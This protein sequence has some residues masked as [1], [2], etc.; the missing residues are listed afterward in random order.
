MWV[1]MAVAIGTAAATPKVDVDLVP[2][3]QGIVVSYRFPRPIGGFAWSDSSADMQARGFTP[4]DGVVIAKSAATSRHPR[5]IFQ[6]TL[7]P[8][9]E[10]LQGHYGFAHQTTDGGWIVYAPYLRLKS[11]QVRLHFK[12][13]GQPRSFT[14]KNDDSHYVV[15]RAKGVTPYETHSWTQSYIEREFAAATAAYTVAFGPLGFQTQR[16]YA[17]RSE[18]SIQ[19]SGDATQ[20]AQIVFTVPKGAGW[21][22]PNPTAQD[23]LNKLV[24]HETFHLWNSKRSHDTDSDNMVW[25]GSAEYLSY[26]A[27]LRAGKLTPRA[28]ASRLTH[29]L[30]QCA[31]IRAHEE[32]TD[33]RKL[34]G[35]GIY[36]C[37]F[38]QEW[39][40]DGAPTRPEALGVNAFPMW[41]ALMKQK[42]YDT[43]SYVESASKAPAYAAF[44]KAMASGDWSGFTE[45]LN[46]LGVPIRLDRPS[47]MHLLFDLAKVVVENCPTGQAGGAGGPDNAGNWFL[48][49]GS[50]CGTLSNQPKITAVDDIDFHDR[51]EDAADHIEAACRAG[52]VLTFSRKTDRFSGTIVCK[53]ALPPPPPEFVVNFSS[54]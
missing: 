29:S 27:L 2:N 4:L 49:T 7:K 53:A 35:W 22:V 20:T 13:D 5:K 52:H 17:R 18:S 41:E 14:P 11:S 46:G 42:T 26:V 44:D 6:F 48:D 16:L 39:L 31:N 33:W 36:D 32:P 25:E 15:V 45:R 10:V 30:D 28:F 3:A 9:A 23:S 51:P 34:T 40:A 47:A 43:K 21:D 54:E 50:E 8:D 19:S 24:W 37:G 38:V 1:A 12:I